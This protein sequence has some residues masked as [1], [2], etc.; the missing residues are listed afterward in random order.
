[1]ITTIRRDWHVELITA[2]RPYP[3]CP[4]GLATFHVKIPLWCWTELQTHGRIARNAASGRAKTPKRL[5]EQDG[6]WIPDAIY[7]DAVMGDSGNR[8]SPEVEFEMQQAMI[9]HIE[10]TEL[11]ML[12][13]FNRGATRQT[14]N[15]LRT[16]N[17]IIEGIMTAT[18]PAWRAVLALRQVDEHGKGADRALAELFSAKVQ[19]ALDTA[20]WNISEWHIPLYPHDLDAATTDLA[21]ILDTAAARI[22]RVSFGDPTALSP[23]RRPDLALAADCKASKHASPFEH[24]A[25]WS[26]EANSSRLNR[27]AFEAAPSRLNCLPED[28]HENAAWQ[29]YR[30][31]LGLN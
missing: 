22:A 4:V 27:L 12:S 19:S 5:L 18:L 13:F 15:R 28:R 9:A 6:V 31:M 24:I 26:F 21:T 23:K 2:T 16:T 1:M 29:T 14:V 20:D 7:A 25:H 11:L 30:N 10:A 17:H 3:S 8:L